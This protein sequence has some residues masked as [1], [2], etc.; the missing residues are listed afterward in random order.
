MCIAVMRK[1]RDPYRDK[2]LVRLKA[3]EVPQDVLDCDCPNVT[4][5][6]PCP[7]LHRWKRTWLEQHGY[8]PEAWTLTLEAWE[9]DLV[10]YCAPE[11]VDPPACSQ[12]TDALPGRL[13]KINVLVERAG[14]YLHACRSC[15]WQDK[16][17]RKVK[18]CPVCSGPV[19]L[20]RRK[21]PE[22]LWHPHDLTLVNLDRLLVE[23]QHAPNGADQRG[24]ARSL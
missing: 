21:D 24:E 9:S 20:V 11:Y 1:T 10:L 17:D 23:I 18:S 12:P 13:A 3:L 7:H 22:Q 16:T 15:T 8:D 2:Q 14:Y 4:L 19:R 5:T 6:S